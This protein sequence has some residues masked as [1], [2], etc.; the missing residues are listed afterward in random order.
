MS[1]PDTY[2]I[3]TGGYTFE[4]RGCII[5]GDKAMFRGF[6]YPTYMNGDA[7]W[8][9]DFCEKHKG[10][11]LKDIKDGKIELQYIV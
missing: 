1:T 8:I 6:F 2:A 10:T 3:E 7:E 4:K 11:N 5:F 9:G